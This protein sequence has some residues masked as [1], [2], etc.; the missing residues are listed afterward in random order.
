MRKGERLILVGMA[1]L[2]IGLMIFNGR[3][4]SEVSQSEKDLPFYTTASTKLN[5]EAMSVYRKYECK[6]CHSLW[7]VKDMLRTVP[8]PALDGIGSLRDR[9]WLATYLASPDPQSILPSR[10]KPEFRMPSYAHMATD[11][12]RVLVDYLASLKV[13]DWY[14]PEVK[15][16][17]CRKLTGSDCPTVDSKGDEAR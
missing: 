12:R 15:R 1:V 8:A 14:L 10:L 6:S 9:E 17:E 16:A 7:T 2:V 5:R 3:R 13:K 11:E 4:Q